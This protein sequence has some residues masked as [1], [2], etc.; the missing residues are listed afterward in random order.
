[1][2][3]KQP[4]VIHPL[5][6]KIANES[7]KFFNYPSLIALNILYAILLALVLFS[8]QKTA[9]KKFHSAKLSLKLSLKFYHQS[10]K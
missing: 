1:M 5:I 9:R 10:F 2:L 8:L 6:G 3:I 7:D 4:S